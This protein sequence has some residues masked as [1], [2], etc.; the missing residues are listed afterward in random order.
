MA[1]R[2]PLPKSNHFHISA[3]PLRLKSE[4]IQM[5]NSKRLQGLRSPEITNEVLYEM[6]TDILENQAILEARLQK[7]SIK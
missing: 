5:R 3:D 4:E 2:K 7:L 1:T 6:L